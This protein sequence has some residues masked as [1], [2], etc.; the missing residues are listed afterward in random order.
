ML[1]L[2]LPDAEFGKEFLASWKSLSVAEHDAVDFSFDTVGKGKT[3]KFNFDKLLDGFNLDS[4]MTEG[5]EGVKKVTGSKGRSSEINKHQGLKT[6]FPEAIPDCEDNAMIDNVQSMR[7]V[8]TSEIEVGTSVTSTCMPNPRMDDWVPQPAVISTPEQSSFERTNSTCSQGSDQQDYSLDKTALREVHI[9][10]GVN[11]NLSTILELPRKDLSIVKSSNS[12]LGEEQN[13]WEEMLGEATYSHGN[14]QSEGSSVPHVPGTEGKAN[15]SNKPFI[16]TL[17]ATKADNEE[18]KPA[19]SLND[20]ACI[21]PSKVLHDSEM[22]VFRGQ[23]PIRCRLVHWN[24]P[25]SPSEKRSFRESPEAVVPAQV[26]NHE[27]AEQ[28][29]TNSVSGDHPKFQLKISPKARSTEVGSPLVMETDENVEKAEAYT[30]E[31]EDICNMLKK[32]QKEAKELLVRAL[33]TNNNLL[34]PNHAIYEVQIRRVQKF[35]SQLMS[36]EIHT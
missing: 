31:L 24:G 22:A 25:E 28:S 30:K 8:G 12:A 21:I 11:T 9:A 5:E 7:C 1:Y 3:K 18:A 10:P 27:N 15:G 20:T 29:K 34:M 13:N 32:K 4:P 23:F 17:N 19:T 14:M 16:V 35:A 36:K 6:H 26:C 33:V 2:I